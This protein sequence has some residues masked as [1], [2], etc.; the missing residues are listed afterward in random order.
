MGVEKTVSKS[1]NFILIAVLILVIANI[2]TAS[3]TQLIE[4]DS[5]DEKAEQT[6]EEETARDSN[7]SSYRWAL[8]EET[9]KLVKVYNEEKKLSPD[10]VKETK[11]REN[12]LRDQIPEEYQKPVT[13][14]E[15]KK[16]GIFEKILDFFSLHFS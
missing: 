1:M 3:A 10:S 15:A 11:E 9:G 2:G 13:V 4:E 5:A 14:K 12:E 16:K 6:D 8:D 7:E